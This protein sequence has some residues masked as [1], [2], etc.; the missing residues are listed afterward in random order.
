MII[1]KHV[2]NIIFVLLKLDGALSSNTMAH[3]MNMT[4]LVYAV[5]VALQIATAWEVFSKWNDDKTKSTSSDMIYRGGTDGSDATTV[6]GRSYYKKD[7]RYRGKFEM[8]IKVSSIYGGV[9]YDANALT[10]RFANDS[11]TFRD[12]DCVY[13]EYEDY[14][15]TT[16]GCGNPSGNCTRAAGIS[17]H[18]SNENFPAD[19]SLPLIYIGGGD[20]AV[21]SPVHTTV[22]DPGGFPTARDVACSEHG[23][24]LL[25]A[26]GGVEAGGCVCELGRYGYFC[27]G[28]LINLDKVEYNDVSGQSPTAIDSTTLAADVS[29]FGG[30]NADGANPSQSDLDSQ[31]HVHVG[32][33]D[34]TDGGYDNY[35]DLNV[36]ILAGVYLI[37]SIVLMAYAFLASWNRYTVT[38]MLGGYLAE[39]NVNALLTYLN[40][41]PEIAL[42]GLSAAI[43]VAGIESFRWNG[44]METGT[45]TL[46]TQQPQMLA[47]QRLMIVIT[48]TVLS[49]TASYMRD[50]KASGQNF[51]RGFSAELI[52]VTASVV[53]IIYLVTILDDRTERMKQLALP[54]FVAFLAFEIIYLVTVVST[55][56][57]TLGAM[58]EGRGMGGGNIFANVEFIGENTIVA[59][60]QAL[61]VVLALYVS[62]RRAANLYDTQTGTTDLHR[63]TPFMQLGTRNDLCNFIDDSILTAP[64]ADADAITEAWTGHRTCFLNDPTTGAALDYTRCC[65]ENTGGDAKWFLRGSIWVPLTICLVSLVLVSADTLRMLRQTVAT[66]TKSLSLDFLPNFMRAKTSS[67]PSRYS[68]IRVQTSLT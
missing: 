26:T 51:L 18:G 31:T 6:I 22:S 7:D 29:T 21:A 10:I 27:E 9:D 15:A 49:R 5:L 43:V 8:E 19:D 45:E 60:C 17:C 20:C 61:A 59:A 44:V 58:A 39:E 55:R 13:D 32:P 66:T 33:Y 16:A 14:N 64:E 62:S 35:A 2:T 25:S 40:P 53:N 54:I 41:I 52:S 57:G 63:G 12:G 1:I 23:V 47:Y 11:S 38:S 4:R 24:C 68:R 67:I 34:T 42:A 46:G 36:V 3:N 30:G 28:E 50:M 65:T 48:L 37:I 56:A